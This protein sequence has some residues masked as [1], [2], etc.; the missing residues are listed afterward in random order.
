MTN[1]YTKIYDIGS[2][3]QAIVSNDKVV[4]VTKFKVCPYVWFGEMKDKIDSGEIAW[5]AWNMLG[6]YEGELI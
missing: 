6:N 2:K 4:N 3:V 1:P 5:V